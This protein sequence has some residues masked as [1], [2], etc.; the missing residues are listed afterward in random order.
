MGGFGSGRN[1]GKMTT[2]SVRSINVKELGVCGR[3]TESVQVNYEKDG[4]SVE[5]IISLSHTACNYGGT[6]CWFRCPYCSRSVGILYLASGQC[7]CRHCFSL[8]HK[9]GQES[10]TDRLFRKVGKIRERL[11]WQPGIAQPDGEKPKGMHWETFD[12]LIAEHDAIT[13]RILGWVHEW[14][15][16]KTSRD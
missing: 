10:S 1:F 3:T 6:R 16:K 14:C 7:A 8:V 9:S 2:N 13:Q 4:Q 15:E 11:G 5:H 12:R